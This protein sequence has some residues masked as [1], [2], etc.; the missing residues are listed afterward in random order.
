MMRDGPTIRDQAKAVAQVDGAVRYRYVFRRAGGDWYRVPAW[1]AAHV[2]ITAFRIDMGG[3]LEDIA[4]RL[5]TVP[6]CIEVE[7]IRDH[8]T[9]RPQVRA[10]YTRESDR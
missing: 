10:I 9:L 1:S 4:E 3:P 6:G 2:M 8:P 5:R 7:C